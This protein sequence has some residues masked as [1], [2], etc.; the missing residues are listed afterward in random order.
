MNTGNTGVVHLTEELLKIDSPF[1]ENKG[2]RK[3]V[4]VVSGL[5]ETQT[6]INIFTEVLRQNHKD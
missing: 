1:M 4:Y 2:F 6:K 3:Q 5:K